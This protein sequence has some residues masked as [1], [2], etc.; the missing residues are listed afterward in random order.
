V[1]V[2]LRGPF[3]WRVVIDG[4]R[5]HADMRGLVTA[6]RGVRLEG[7]RWSSNV[8]RDRMIARLSIGVS[9]VSST[10]PGHPGRA[11]NGTRLFIRPWLFL[12]DR[13]GE[14]P[15][16]A[17]QFPGDGDVR[18]DPAFVPGLELL[19]FPVQPVVALMAADPGRLVG[20]LPAG[21]HVT[22]G[23][24]VGPAV[25]PGCLDQQAPGHGCCRSW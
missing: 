19:P 23:V 13:G 6:G 22:A 9:R 8:G 7:C 20:C 2:L 15:A 18:D 16:P 21:A 3:G 10:L 14:G 11:G 1:S 12:L 4:R 17:G 25:V 5:C 24:V